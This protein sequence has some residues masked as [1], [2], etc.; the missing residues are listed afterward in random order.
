MNPEERG[1]RLPHPE[2]ADHLVARLVYGA[3]QHSDRSVGR[4]VRSSSIRRVSTSF[5]I[6]VILL[7]GY[8]S[9]QSGVPATASPHRLVL[10]DVGFRFEVPATWNLQ[11]PDGGPFAAI[12]ELPPKQALALLTRTPIGPDEPENKGVDDLLAEL[13]RAFSQ[14][15]IVSKERQQVTAN[16]SGH[17]VEVRGTALG[18][19]LRHTTYLIEGFGERFALTFATEDHR[20]AELAPIFKSIAA[21]LELTGPNP[22]SAR[23]LALIKTDPQ[24]L[25]QLKQLLDAGADVNAVDSEGLNALAAAVMSRNGRLTKWLL[26]HGA[27]PTQSAKMA[28]LLPIIATPPIRELLVR[29]NPTIPPAPRGGEA[30]A[31]EIQWVSPEAQL[32]SG[33]RNARLADVEEA[34]KAGAD[35]EALE[36][37]YGLPALALT[38]KLIE[39][40]EQ[41]ELDS[42]RFVPIETLLVEAVS[43]KP[44]PSASPR[45]NKPPIPF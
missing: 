20:H 14:Y 4:P 5:A 32:F 11:Q 7:A 42:D 35:L 31:L 1:V 37:N 17:V 6:L 33:I 12:A 43:S 38:R 19:V 16:L 26:E 39:E 44:Q 3:D 36:P 27:D 2:R 13:P 23:F 45:P 22:H 9:A 21:T 30:K 10:A 40:F 41:L 28:S 15:E 29:A 8:A 24:D 18:R 25:A 34:I